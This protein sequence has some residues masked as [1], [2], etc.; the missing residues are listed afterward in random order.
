MLAAHADIERR[1]QF[2][3]SIPVE[4]WIPIQVLQLQLALNSSSSCDDACQYSAFDILAGLVE[5]S[6]PHEFQT[7]VEA[8]KGREADQW[9]LRLC[10]CPHNP[11]CTHFT[12]V[13][14]F[15]PSEFKHIS[16]ISNSSETTP[17][18]L[19]PSM[20]TGKNSFKVC[21][22]RRSKEFA[23]MQQ[24]ERALFQATNHNLASNS[25]ST[26]LCHA[27]RNQL[28]QPSSCL[29]RSPDILQC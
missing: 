12:R 17:L 18:R 15:M 25:G 9:L 2:G 13:A 26:V 7:R 23:L 14:G 24:S 10:S 16:P 3:T 19:G 27:S 22:Q 20:Q 21:N 6:P 28:S 5:S 1:Q 29:V 4:I 8:L 11:S